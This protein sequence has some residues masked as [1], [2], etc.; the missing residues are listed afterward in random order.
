[1][2]TQTLKT[3]TFHVSGMHCNSCVVLIE[4]ELGDLPEVRKVTSYLASHS[5]EVVGDFGDKK[6]EHIAKDLSEILKPHGYSLSVERKR[7]EVKWSDFK[8]AV[9]IAIGFVALFIILQ[10]LGIVNLVTT[11]KVGFGTA[12]IIGFIASVFNYFCTPQD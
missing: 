10:K 3:Y 5:V 1:M 9:P 12:F 2:S 7:H 6:L 11:A 8:I 4:S